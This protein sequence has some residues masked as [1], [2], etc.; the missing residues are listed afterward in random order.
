[1]KKNIIA[2]I[3]IVLFVFISACC[4]GLPHTSVDYLIKNNSGHII[5]IHTV[6]EQ[7]SKIITIGAS[8]QIQERRDFEKRG[9]GFCPFFYG[10][11]TLITFDDTVFVLHYENEID[12]SRYKNVYRDENWAIKE[13]G[14]KGEYEYYYEYVFTDEDYQEALNSQ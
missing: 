6:G 13:T 2:I 7:G 14:K 11:S 3:G 10:D 4:T 5:K 12:Q 8:E 1:M 9:A